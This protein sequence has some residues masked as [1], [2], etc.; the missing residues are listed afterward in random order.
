MLSVNIKRSLSFTKSD[1]Y[2]LDNLIVRLL[3]RILMCILEKTLTACVTTW[4]CLV[5]PSF[6]N[7]GSK[8]LWINLLIWTN[9]PDLM[10]LDFSPILRSLYWSLILFP[11]S[12][13]FLLC[14]SRVCVR[15]CDS[16]CMIVCQL[17]TNKDSYK[18]I[19]SLTVSVFGNHW[20]R[21]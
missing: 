20:R 5:Y 4:M 2:R 11:L 1:I 16:V 3:C 19:F 7:Q 17:L 10:D 15:L 14:L 6:L 12:L 21:V 9:K 13:L 8:D 18:Y